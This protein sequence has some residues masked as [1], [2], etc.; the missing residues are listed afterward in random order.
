MYGCGHDEDPHRVLEALSD[1][2]KHG[3]VIYITE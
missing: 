2:G 3:K 1:I